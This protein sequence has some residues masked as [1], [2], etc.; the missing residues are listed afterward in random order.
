[1]ETFAATEELRFVPNSLLIGGLAGYPPAEKYGSRH[2]N[3]N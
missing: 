2:F 3:L 1:M